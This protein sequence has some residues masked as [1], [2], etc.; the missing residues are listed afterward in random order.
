L[1]LLLVPLIIALY[2]VLI[3]VAVAWCVI[4][5]AQVVE[6]AGVLGSFTRS[7]Q[8][9]KNNRWRIFGLFVLWGI[10]SSV[11]Q[12]VLTN[13]VGAGS[14]SSLAAAQATSPAA[15]L[16]AFGPAYWVIVAVMG[17]VGAMV[18]SAGVAVVYYEL[19]RIKEGIGPEA[20]ASVFD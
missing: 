16:A 7:G 17:V 1:L 4:F 10:V 18:G 12:G 15:A 8:L 19:R 20:L 11:V 2:V 9:T 13:L 3:M 14:A 6:R 5:P